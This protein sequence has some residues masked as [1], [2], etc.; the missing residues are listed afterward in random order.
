MK[1]FVL[2]NQDLSSV[3]ENKLTLNEW[4]SSMF[5]IKSV[6]IQSCNKTPNYN[7]NQLKSQQQSV[8]FAVLLLQML[9]L[10]YGCFKNKNDTYVEY[11]AD[12]RM[13]NNS[14]R[15]KIVVF[16]VLEG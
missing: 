15:D 10:S 8:S 5:L 9:M 3:E 16:I 11:A 2:L 4:G 14:D 6:L 7:K 12:N 1:K 13:G